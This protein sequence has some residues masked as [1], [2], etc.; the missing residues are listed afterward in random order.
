MV[1]RPVRIDISTGIYYLVSDSVNLFSGNGFN[2][3]PNI[4]FIAGTRPEVI[5]VAPAVIEARKIYPEV[6][7]L[8]TGQ[9]KAMARQAL[10][11]FG[12]Q[13]DVELDVMRAGASL[14]DLTTRLIKALDAVYLARK[15]GVVVVQGD[16]SS[17]AIAGLIVLNDYPFNSQ[18]GEIEDSAAT[19]GAGRDAILNGYIMDVDL[20]VG[21]GL[22]A[23][24]Q[25]SAGAMT[26]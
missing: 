22:Q 24:D 10:E 8:L 13:A 16:T 1:G 12:L 4:L 2:M 23:G 17:A 11:A 19:V 25:H 15:P 21:F 5:K 20:L 3:V 9:H 14:S 26:G 7:L 6:T 18:V